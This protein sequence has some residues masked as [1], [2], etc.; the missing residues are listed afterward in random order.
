M[1]WFKHDSDASSDA[2]IRKL[3]EVADESRARIIK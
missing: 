2:K 1:K 3:V